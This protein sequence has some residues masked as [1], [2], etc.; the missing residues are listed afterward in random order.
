MPCHVVFDSKLADSSPIGTAS[1]CRMPQA[2]ERGLRYWSSNNQ[3]EADRGWLVKADTVE[4][5]VTVLAK[6]SGHDAIDA[7]ALAETIEQ[8]NGPCETAGEEGDVFGRTSFD[9]IDTQ[10]YYAAELVTGAVYSMGGLKPGMR[11]ETLALNGEPI[12]RLYHADDVAGEA[13]ADEA[14]VAVGLEIA[15]LGDK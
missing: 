11:C 6:Q 7:A 3:D 5:L 9:A 10:A 14:D 4:E 8:Y 15:N 12:P 1:S 2:G 13:A